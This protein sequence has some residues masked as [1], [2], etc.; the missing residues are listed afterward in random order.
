MQSE[1]D[2][3][4]DDDDRLTVAVVRSGGVAGLRR[5]WRVE[6]PR[7]EKTVW[8]ALIERC[9]W[10]APRETDAGADRFVWSIQVRTAGEERE[11]ELADSELRGAWRELVDAVREADAGRRGGGPDATADDP[12]R[13]G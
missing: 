7:P 12:E 2:A 9:P 1:P 10:D 3:Q 6:P 4:G 13:R 8:I 11:R 5:R